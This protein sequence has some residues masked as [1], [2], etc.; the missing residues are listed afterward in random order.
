MR[1]EHGG[2]ACRGSME[3]GS[4]VQHG[5]ASKV[6]H[7]FG[8]QEQKAVEAK[9]AMAGEHGRAPETLSC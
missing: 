6:T 1:G 4:D 3:R 5:E 7:A 9:G 8:G 2:Q